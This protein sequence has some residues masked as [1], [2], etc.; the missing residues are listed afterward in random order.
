M[1]TKTFLGLLIIA[2]IIIIFTSLSTCHSGVVPYV[3]DSSKLPKYTYEEGFRG[4]LDYTS[5]PENE[6]IESSMNS[7]NATN[8]EYNKIDPSSKARADPKVS[9]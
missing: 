6:N 2:F 7:Q 3:Y 9:Q 1:K 8:S 4:I 5:Y